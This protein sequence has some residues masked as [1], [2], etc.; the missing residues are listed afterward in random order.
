METEPQKNMD[1][2]KID[3]DNYEQIIALKTEKYALPLRN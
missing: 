1:Y 3:V 2:S